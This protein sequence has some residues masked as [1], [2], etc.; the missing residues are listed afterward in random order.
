[1]QPERERKAT[2]WRA[3]ARYFTR[4]P[5]RSTLMA[6]LGVGL[7][8][9]A[10]TTPRADRDWYPYLARTAQVEAAQERF[11]V[12]PVSDW[13]Y[14]ANGVVAERYGEAAVAFADLR[15]VWFMLEPQPGSTLAAH[16]LLLF[17]FEGDRLLG[18]TIEARRE[19]QEDYSALTGLFNAYELAYVWASARDLLTRRAVMLDHEVFVYPVDIPLARAQDLLRR[20]LE[21]TDALETGPRFY[22]TVTSNCTNE[23]A[24][25]ADLGWHHSFVFTGTSDNYLFR[26]GVLPGASFADANVRADIT[27]WL[28]AANEAVPESHFDAALLA[29][30]RRRFDEH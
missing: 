13:S 27:H 7:V 3:R 29:E 6:L 23:L 12:A 28:K 16:T 19:R 11:A 20:T 15:R 4:R 14:D 30:L 21:R 25:A 22:N 1:M 9:C 8:S 2:G 5:L 24:K 17:E 26:R 18:L 10:S